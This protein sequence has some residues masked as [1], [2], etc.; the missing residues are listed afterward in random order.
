MAHKFDH[1]NIERLDNPQRVQW[2]SPER[3]LELV[4]PW[5]GMSYADIGCGVGYFTFPVAERVG[6]Q[7]TIY[8]V[9]IQPEMLEELARRA[10]ARG[11]NN[12]ITVQ[13]F[14]REIPLASAC[15]DAACLANT[16]HELEDPVAFLHEICRILKPGGRLFVIDW[17]AIETPMGPPLRERVSAET[18]S[19]ALQ[20]V[21]F[22]QL[23][24]HPI[25][26]YHYVLEASSSPA[27][28]GN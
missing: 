28:G 7:G 16:F 22:S 11:L 5:A 17:K 27:Q 6:P 13:C 8:A 24:E 18:V 2:Q 12:V 20:T 3:F 10:R 4:R 23:R 14:E 1:R 25:Y 26:P 15:V 21:G 19:Q 9:D